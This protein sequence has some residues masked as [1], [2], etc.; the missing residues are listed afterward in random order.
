MSTVL[1]ILRTPRSSRPAK[2]QNVS[3]LWCGAEW[4]ASAPAN[5]EP[6]NSLVT[7]AIVG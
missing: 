4:A 6:G 3:L 2:L 7:P 1:P 5:G